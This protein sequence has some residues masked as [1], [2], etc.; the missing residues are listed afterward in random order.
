MAPRAPVAAVLPRVCAGVCSRR[1]PILR[2]NGDGSLP[3][4]AVCAWLGL[5]L[6]EPRLPPPWATE[7]VT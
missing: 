4:R 7:G 3:R 5:V 1:A 6:L 2:G